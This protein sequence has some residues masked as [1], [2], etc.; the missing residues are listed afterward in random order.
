[1]AEH[2]KG[3]AP[4]AT[5]EAPHSSID[6]NNDTPKQNQKSS[7]NGRTRNFAKLVYPTKEYYEQWYEEHP[8]DTET[9][10]VTPHYDGADGY[11]DAPDNWMDILDGFHVGA[12]ISPLH[13]YDRN[14]DGTLKKPHFH[15]MLMFEGVKT[16][17]QAD[18][19]FDA[20]HGVGKE[21]IQSAR[22]YARYLQHLDNPEKYQYKERPKCLG[23]IDYDAI[24]HLPGDDTANVK[25]MMKY[26]RV[27][28]ISSFAEFCDICATNNEEW[29]NA[30]VHRSAYIIKEYIKSIQWELTHAT[31]DER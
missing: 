1:M 2:K 6:T 22:G 5:D 10:E 19:I 28:Q 26:I 16:Q 20:I 9:G 3:A 13:A 23:G 14:P 18:E 24:I 21:E 12:L 29:F 4:Q 8:C 15:V 11:G 31:E 25:D 17:K 27:N 30:L 7:G